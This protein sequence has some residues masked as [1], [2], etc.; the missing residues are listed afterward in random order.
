MKD[1]GPATEDEMV[2]AFVQ[3]ELDADRWQ[4]EL[5]SGPAG[6]GQAEDPRLKAESRE[7]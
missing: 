4:G 3:A 1:V 7:R 2:L 5:R 6:N